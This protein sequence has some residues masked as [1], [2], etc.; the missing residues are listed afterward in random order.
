MRH[1]TSGK[2]RNVPQTLRVWEV[3]GRVWKRGGNKWVEVRLW[4]SLDVEQAGAEEPICLYARRLP[5]ARHPK[6]SARS[7]GSWKIE[8]GALLRRARAANLRPAHH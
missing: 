8:T 7:A 4:T 2:P 1:P 3:R 5:A 6:S